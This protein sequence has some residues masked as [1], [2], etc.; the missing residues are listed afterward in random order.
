MKMVALWKNLPLP[1][2]METILKSEIFASELKA[3][4]TLP[5]REKHLAH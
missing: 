3:G 1:V 5:Q 4:I 2:Q